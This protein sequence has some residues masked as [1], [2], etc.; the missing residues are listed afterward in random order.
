MKSLQESTIPGPP[1]ARRPG[2]GRR[3]G[4][5]HSLGQTPQTR[6]MILTRCEAAVE[7]PPIIIKTPHAL[8][9]PLRS[10]PRAGATRVSGRPRA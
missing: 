7:P 8:A 9:L 10:R 2:P 4:L 6:L 3:S 5:P 1:H